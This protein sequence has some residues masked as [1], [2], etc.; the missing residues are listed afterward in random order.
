MRGSPVQSQVRLPESSRRT[1]HISKLGTS[2]PQPLIL[3]MTCVSWYELCLLWS[4]TW[5]KRSPDHSTGTAESGPGRVSQGYLTYKTTHPPS[6]DPT[7]GPCLGSWAGPREVGIFLWVRYPCITGALIKSVY[8][9]G[10]KPT[11]PPCIV[12]RD[13]PDLPVGPYSR[14]MPR[15]IGRA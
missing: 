5:C 3:A 6:Q 1:K 7:V 15:V 2:S 10:S 14:T 11:W 9:K 13:N 4:S 8:S 12:F